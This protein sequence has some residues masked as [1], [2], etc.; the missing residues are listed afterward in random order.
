MPKFIGG[1]IAG[2]NEMGH[3]NAGETAVFCR[4]SKS[5]ADLLPPEMVYYS[6]DTTD[7]G[8]RKQPAKRWY[9]WFAK[10][11]EVLQHPSSTPAMR[12]RVLSGP[13]AIIRCTLHDDCKDDWKLAT[14]CAITRAAEEEARTARNSATS[15]TIPLGGSNA[16]A[17]S[18]L[19]YS[20]R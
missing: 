18:T 12:N 5:Q 10:R 6:L 2:A 7:K 9:R 16:V 14:I 20:Q 13:V 19:T 1:R 4:L 11:L 17:S 15:M 3:D 8:G